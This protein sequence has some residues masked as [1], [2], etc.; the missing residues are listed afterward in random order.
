MNLRN[1]RDTSKSGS[2]LRAGFQFEFHCEICS[3]TWQSPFRPY[4][5]AQFSG[6][7]YRLARLLNDRGLMFRASN[8]LASAG[9][10]GARNSA[11]QEALA[12]AE[13]R[14]TEC[15]AC[16]K[17]VDEECWNER[18]RLCQLCATKNGGR[19]AIA[20]GSEYR[21]SSEGVDGAASSSA[22]L[23]CPNCSLLIGGGR[24]CAECGFD[25][26][27]THKT[28]P[29]CGTLCMRSTRFC[30]DCGHGF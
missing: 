16:H 25:M 6:L 23:K 19:P 29:G 17:A 3:Q 2:D 21:D 20:A 10:G 18:A 26:A 8:S 13:Q 22:G 24:F 27:S 7:M 12:L 14:Y 28:C 5:R 15:P 1:Y 11:L 30:A 4:R 9:E